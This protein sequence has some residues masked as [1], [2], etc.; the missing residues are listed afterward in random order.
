MPIRLF[1][2]CRS[3]NYSD[4]IWNNQTIVNFS[5]TTNWTHPSGSCNFVTV[6][7]KKKINCA[8]SLQIFEQEQN[9]YSMCVTNVSGWHAALVNHQYVILN[10][11]RCSRPSPPVL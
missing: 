2:K 8:Y 3:L 9:Y 1:F 4:A 6:C 11:H 7:K 5:N 10:T